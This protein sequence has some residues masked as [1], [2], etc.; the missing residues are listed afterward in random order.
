MPVYRQGRTYH[1]PAP[2]EGGSNSESCIACV[3]IT[4]FLV[5]APLALGSFERAYHSDMEAFHE[6]EDEVVE[7]VHASSSTSPQIVH[8]QAA[9]FSSVSEDIDLGISVDGALSLERVT[10][11]CQ[12]R[13][14]T[15]EHCKQCPD[16]EGNGTH[17]CD[18][19]IT[20]HYIKDWSRQLYNSAF[21]D[22]PSA[23]WNP[24]RNPY[25]STRFFAP[26]VSATDISGG[27]AT[28]DRSLL[29]SHSVRAT[30]RRVDWTLGAL[31]TPSFWA[32]LFGLKDTTRYE[33]IRALQNVVHTRAY[34]TDKFVYVGQG[35]YFFS[36]YE[37]SNMG[38]LFNWFGQ[39]VEGSLLDWQAGDIVD[40]LGAGCQA[41]DIRVRFEVQDPAEISVIAGLEP[42]N[43]REAT[44]RTDRD[45]QAYTFEQV[46]AWY[47]DSYTTAQIQSYWEG[48]KESYAVGLGTFHTPKG[49]HIGMVHEGLRSPKQMF[50]AVLSDDWWH[51]MFA[52]LFLAPWAWVVGSYV[53]C[54]P[55]VGG[56][57]A[58][59]TQGDP[60]TAA[61]VYFVTLAL[62]WA[63]VWGIQ[64]LDSDWH[65]VCT[66]A[67]L[68][69]GLGLVSSPFLGSST[70]AGEESEQAKTK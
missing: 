30:S 3:L 9:S 55:W 20:F 17:K 51:C 43:A 1:V 15:T 6:V 52:R 33:E 41:G 44:R 28:L 59:L 37:G 66:P 58:P 42:K 48:M 23:H 54:P 19:T 18:C 67:F 40:W 56:M 62:F 27:E 26:H 49:H 63:A 2:R 45:G 38:Q 14:H 21:F 69:L 36:R 68:A 32:R 60:R 31:P 61:G 47:K 4:L 16:R 35:G 10:E 64:L 53:M 22:Q 24:Q 39:Y 29:N 70:H 13:E 11:Y 65:D 50:D 34:T 46:R 8:L 12:W 5:A 25:P 7:L 57:T